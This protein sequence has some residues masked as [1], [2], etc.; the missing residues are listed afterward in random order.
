MFQIDK[1]KLKLEIEKVKFMD[2]LIEQKIGK[3][4]LDSSLSDQ[5]ILELS[6]VGEF[7]SLF[8]NENIEILKQFE[9]PDFILSFNGKELGLEHESIMNETNVKKTQS[10]KDLFKQ[11]EKEFKNKYP[12]INLIANCWLK[13]NKLSFKK[14]DKI[15]IVNQIVDYIYNLKRGLTINKPDFI[16]DVRLMKHSKISF[17][18]N[19]EI[20]DIKPLDNETLLKAINKIKPTIKIA[21]FLLF[22]SI[23][24]YML[25]NH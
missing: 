13:T 18:C 1:N 12:D 7:L 8:D 6:H 5:K 19:L 4:L 20:S 14:I 16:R 24:L 25:Y 2:I 3:Y 21:D 9:S 11:A 17:S 22:E 23:C 15:E 10:I